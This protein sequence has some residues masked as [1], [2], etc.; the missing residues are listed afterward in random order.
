MTDPDPAAPAE[1]GGRIRRET[2][3]KAPARARWRLGSTLGV[4]ASIRGRESLGGLSN[5]GVSGGF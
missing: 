3:G 2:L 5:L 4:E 1:D